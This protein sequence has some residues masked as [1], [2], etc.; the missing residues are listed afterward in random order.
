[1]TRDEFWRQ[2]NVYEWEPYQPLAVILTSGVRTYIDM[3]EQAM[4]GSGELVIT[5]RNSPR[6][7]ERYPYA[8]IDRLVPLMELPADPGGMKYADFD[9]L[10]RE[11]LMADPFEPFVIELK[12]G[13]RIE[14]D[15]RGGTTRA[16]R[17]IV[18]LG[19]P[20]RPFVHVE[21][22]QVARLMRKE[23]ATAGRG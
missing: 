21:F 16:G 18:L 19:E 2:Y 6:K 5:R 22:D 20:P 11:L 14:L 9:P 13:E 17:F 4:P 23:L 15:E 1:M 3:P 12:N 10:I 7:P 8:D